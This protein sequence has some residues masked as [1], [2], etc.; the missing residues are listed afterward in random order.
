MREVHKK[1]A[2][3]GLCRDMVRAD[4]QRLVQ[5]LIARKF[6]AEDTIFYKKNIY[7]ASAFVRL[8]D[9]AAD[10]LLR[11]E[12]FMFSITAKKAKSAATA[13][14][15]STTRGRGRGSA[16]ATKRAIVS[17][18]IPDDF[19]DFGDDEA[20]V[21]GDSYSGGGGQDEWEAEEY[22]F[23]EGNS[24]DDFIVPD[25]DWES[26]TDYAAG[27]SRGRGG[28]A[29]GT[30]GRGFTTANR[31]RTT[32]GRGGGGGYKRGAGTSRGRATGS[33]R[34]GSTYFKKRGAAASKPGGWFAGSQASQMMAATNFQDDD[35]FIT[36]P[37]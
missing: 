12:V 27:P 36:V 20:A 1:T 15:T 29:R 6:L 16:A 32:R 13:S 21:D 18:Q 33:A 3:Y 14:K 26:S 28:R 37:D 19:E 2:M 23:G 35:G 11:N 17:F 22:N 4:V 7:A 8:G 10:V 31:V 30:R 25:D 5:N 34:G 24:L 9:R